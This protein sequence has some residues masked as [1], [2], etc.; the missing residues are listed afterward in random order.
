MWENDPPFEEF[1]CKT[2][3]PRNVRSYTHKFSPTCLHKHELNKDSKTRQL[4]W[5]G[6]GHEASTLYKELQTTE[7]FSEREKQSSP[8]K[9]T[10]IDYPTPKS[11]PGEGTYK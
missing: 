1:F 8:W 3:C 10:P 6:K 2:L 7:E 4:K 11:Q 9:S 5:I